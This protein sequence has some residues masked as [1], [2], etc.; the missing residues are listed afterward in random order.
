MPSCA[1]CRLAEITRFNHFDRHLL[2]VG[3]V[4][5]ILSAQDQARDLAS[6]FVLD[7]EFKVFCILVERAVKIESAAD[8]ARLRVGVCVALNR[9]WREGADAKAEFVD[10]V[11]DVR[12]LSAL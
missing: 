3:D 12:P 6:A 1:H 5:G 9:F 7:P 2:S 4:L 8:R 11:L 10:K